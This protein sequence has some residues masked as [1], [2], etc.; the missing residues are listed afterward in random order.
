[1][2][3]FVSKSTFRAKASEY[4]R[5]VESTGKGLVIT[6]YGKPVLKLVPYGGDS[7][8]ILRSLRGSVIRYVD[9]LEPAG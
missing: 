7:E 3:R 8:E 4:F 1:M 5:E 9:P 2:D 6:D